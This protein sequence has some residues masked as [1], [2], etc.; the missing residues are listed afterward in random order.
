MER[1]PKPGEFYRHFKDKL[2]QVVTVARHT[3][4]G[5]DLVVYQALYGDFKTYAR[6][7]AMFLSEVDHEKYPKAVQKY[8]F[9]KVELSGVNTPDTGLNLTSGSVTAAAPG[10]TSGSVKAATP[11]AAIVSE[12]GTAPQAESPQQSTLNPG[13]LS[14]IEA[15]TYEEQMECLARMRGMLKQEEL[16]ILFTALDMDR[17]AGSLEEQFGAVEQILQLQRHYDGG[18]LR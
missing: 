9:E 17:P 6:P 18:H 10:A 8:R 15:E 3:E 12:A 16:D 11:D 13:L 2:Y 4:T 1:I 7:L 5:E 14:F